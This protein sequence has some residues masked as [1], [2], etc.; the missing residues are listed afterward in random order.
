MNRTDFQKYT[1]QY[2]ASLPSSK[3]SD[4]TVI[5][6]GVA[7]KKFSEYLNE[8]NL[9]G[10]ICPLTLVNFRTEM[11][12]TEV[13]SNTI[14]YYMTVLHTFFEWALRM[15]LA[16]QNPVKREEIPKLQEIDYDLL[17]LDEIKKLLTEI[18]KGINHKTALRN[19]AIVILLVQVGLRNSELR[20]L[21]L[22]ALDFEKGCIEIRHG[23]GDKRRV[24]AFPT[25]ARQLIQEY[26]KSGVR[27]PN[28]TPNDYLFGTDCD[29]NGKTT[30]RKVWKPFSPQGLLGLVNRYTRLCCGHEVG[31]HC[32]RHCAT[33]LWSELG[34]EP[35]AI[36]QSLGHSLYSTTEK[37][38]LH[39]LNRQSVSNKI[40]FA[41]DSM[42]GELQ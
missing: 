36:Q 31:V 13:K 30:N 1:E 7:L 25:L 40:N 3:K 20:L 23:K 37:I 17:S 27:P 22:S 26:L 2:I 8:I 16:E 21:P 39:V 33:S 42:L 35:R 29:E 14:A 41:F 12:S 11:Y 9:D 6:Y 38:Y 19:R 32:L 28:L 15:G 18:P 10:E 24:V 5:T 4:K 34:V